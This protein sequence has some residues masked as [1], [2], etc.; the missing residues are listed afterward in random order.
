MSRPM[1]TNPWSICP[2]SHMKLSP[3]KI[4]L[5]MVI[6][7]YIFFT[8]SGPKQIHRYILQLKKLDLAF[9]LELDCHEPSCCR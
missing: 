9:V 5:N 6:R 3:I 8:R 1:L 2:C 7:L 4:K